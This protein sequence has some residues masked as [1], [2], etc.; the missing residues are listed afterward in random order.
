MWRGASYLWPWGFG[1]CAGLELCD[2]P[3]LLWLLPVTQRQHKM[4]LWVGDKKKLNH[5]HTYFNLCNHVTGASHQLV[6]SQTFNLL[7][8]CYN[9]LGSEGQ[10]AVLTVVQRLH[11]AAA[12]HTKEMFTQGA[13]LTCQRSQTTHLILPCMC[14]CVCVGRPNCWPC[15]NRELQLE[16]RR[17]RQDWCSWSSHTDLTDFFYNSLVENK[18]MLRCGNFSKHIHID[19]F[20]NVYVRIKEVLVGLWNV[21]VHQHSPLHFDSTEPVCAST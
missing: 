10:H 7:G 3:G 17:P 14:T 5:F 15:S 18:M 19:I 1:V 2:C 4:C 8:E 16:I 20:L 21:F 6:H 12:R 9:L 11:S 13:I